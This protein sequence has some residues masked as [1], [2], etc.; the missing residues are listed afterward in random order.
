MIF[1]NLKM[2]RTL[3]FFQSLV[4]DPA[5]YKGFDCTALANG[6]SLYFAASTGVIYKVGHDLSEEP[7]LEWTAYAKS[8]SHLNFVKSRNI[9]LSLGV[10]DTAPV[11]K[12]WN[13]GELD[14]HNRPKL[15]KAV[16]IHAGNSNRQFPITVFVQNASLSQI[17]IGFENGVCVLIRGDVA[18]D[19]SVS[20]K[21]FHEASSSITGASSVYQPYL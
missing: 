12:C 6:G 16:K 2:L 10:D 18:R 1:P 4:H 21:V 15:I 19:R 9:L 14:K 17:A 3:P 5:F 11:L 8:I 7:L 13:L 20:Q